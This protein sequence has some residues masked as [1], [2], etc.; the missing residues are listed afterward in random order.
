VKARKAKAFLKQFVSL[1]RTE[2]PLTRLRTLLDSSDS[3]LALSEIAPTLIEHHHNLR[4]AYPALES[5]ET[6]LESLD[7]ALNQP[8]SVSL[9]LGCGDK[10]RNPFRAAEWFGVDIREDLESKILCANLATQPIPC[11]TDHF[12]YCTAFDVIEH[13][14]RILPASD[15]GTHFPFIELMNE[16]HRVLKPGGLFLHQTPAFPCKQAFQDPTHV[17][18]VTEDTFPYYFCEPNLYATK[19]GYGFNGRFELVYQGWIDTAWI[20]GIL[21]AIK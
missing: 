21:K 1:M 20:V 11:Q 6:L 7:N 18:I 9:D 17:N 12:D 10:P 16:V 3:L 5:I 8:A 14:P 15:G 4:K 19:I 13:I 2:H